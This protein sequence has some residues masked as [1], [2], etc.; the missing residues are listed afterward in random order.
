MPRREHV[1]GAPATA[2][3]AGILAAA[4]SFSVTDGSGYPTGAVGPFFVVIDSG[5]STEEK[6]LCASRS[7]NNFTVAG[8][9]RG[10][11]NTTAVD[12]A[13]G[14][15]VQ[16]V[17][18][19]LEVDEHN[20]H[21]NA[22]TGVHGKT[23]A[24]ASLSDAETLTNKTMSGAANSFS[25]IPQS[26]VSALVSDL[27][28]KVAKAD[29]HD[30]WETAFLTALGANWAAALAAGLDSD[31]ASVLGL[32][33]PSVVAVLQNGL[34]TNWSSVL[35]TVLGS[36]W[37]AALDSA[38]GSNWATAFAAT[39]A[40]DWA[41]VLDSPING[42]WLN[43]FAADPASLRPI[44][45]SSDTDLLNQSN[46]T[47]GA[48][49]PV[50]GTAFTAPPSG[51]VEI[52]VSG[53]IASETDTQAIVLGWEMRDGSTVGSGTITDGL[54]IDDDRSIIAGKV[55]NAS[56]PNYMSGSNHFVVDTL[57]AGASHNVRCM[58]YVTGGS[59]HDIF[60]RRL[61]V[62]PVL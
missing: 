3:S 5:E 14:A 4:T 21:V 43:I 60:H 37:S 44:Q 34:G 22:T 19:A 2:L 32:M 28:A 15:V 62:R 56:A 61:V 25:S 27:A 52:I 12:H 46:T 49:S 35:Q 59:T 11:D 51:A 39:L 48:G 54:D 17:L 41:N 47:P 42:G 55:V 8:S 38:L 23:S 40:G 7:G 6:I 33:D 58:H 13:S 10:A 18:A 30:S 26:A 31:A 1:G 24:L 50:V 29:V 20:A 45:V 9:G 53:F 16:H 57:V 36:G